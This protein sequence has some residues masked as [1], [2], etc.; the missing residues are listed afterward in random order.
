M[1]R[2][3]SQDFE[4]PEFL[5][6]VDAAIKDR[7][8][9]TAPRHR[10]S[11]HGCAPISPRELALENAPLLRQLIQLGRSLECKGPWFKLPHVVDGAL[12]HLYLDGHR[13]PDQVLRD[14]ECGEQGVEQGYL[15]GPLNRP[16]GSQRYP[17]CRPQG[18]MTT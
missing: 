1:K 9:G 4:D 3:S 15:V 11:P 18:A 2:A 16:S 17:S 6:A 13:A 7:T 14:L 8:N 12:L 5:A 10:L